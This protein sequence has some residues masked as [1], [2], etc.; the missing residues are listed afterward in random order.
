MVEELLTLPAELVRRGWVVFVL[1]E[2]PERTDLMG[3]SGTEF[4]EVVEI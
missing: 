4:P 2:V 3:T 1:V